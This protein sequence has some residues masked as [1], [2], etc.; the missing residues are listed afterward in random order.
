MTIASG[1]CSQSKRIGF[2][3]QTHF[4]RRP[5]LT[6]CLITLCRVVSAEQQ[7]TDRAAKNTDNGHPNVLLILADDM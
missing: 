3:M 6:L 1:E 4:V 5:V 7:V 2:P